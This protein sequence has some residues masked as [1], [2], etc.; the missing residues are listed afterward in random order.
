LAACDGGAAELDRRAVAG[1]RWPMSTMLVEI[2][3]ALKEAGASEEKARAAAASLAGRDQRWD[4]VGQR[5]QRVEQRLD[6]VERWLDLV[7]QAL[8]ALTRRV[9][10]LEDKVITLAQDVAV[11]RAELGLMKWMHGITIGGVLALLVKTFFG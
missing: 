10:A 8:E 5:F 7:E 6:T 3:D 9:A 11:I 2:Y 4:E 1:H